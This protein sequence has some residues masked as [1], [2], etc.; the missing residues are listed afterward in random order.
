[1]KNLTRIIHFLSVVLILL[2]TIPRNLQVIQTVRAQPADDDLED[3]YAGAAAPKLKGKSDG[4]N[5]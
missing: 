2:D 1:M 3:I 5:D 4:M